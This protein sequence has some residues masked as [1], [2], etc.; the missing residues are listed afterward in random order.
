V[1][2][3]TYAVVTCGSQIV[4]WHCFN[5]WP[6]R[7]ASIGGTTSTRLPA[8]LNYRSGSSSI[9]GTQSLLRMLHETRSSDATDPRDK[10][11]A[12]LGM[13]TDRE[14]ATY[15]GLVD[16]SIPSGYLYQKTASVMLD[17]TGS[18]HFLSAVQPRTSNCQSSL[19]ELPSWV[20]DWSQQSDVTPMALGQNFVEPYNAGGR[21]IHLHGHNAAVLSTHGVR[22]AEVRLVSKG[23]TEARPSRYPSY[24]GFLQSWCDDV[25]RDV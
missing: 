19:S 17:E 15:L 23:G 6:L 8:V 16:Y 3:A 2:L 12:L 9:D 1:S 10:V 24:G 25:E 5:Q 7:Q 20:P 11:I 4:P 14:R 13:L 21:F 18:L 22:V